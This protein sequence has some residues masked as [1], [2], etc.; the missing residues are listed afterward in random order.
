MSAKRDL[1]LAK[2]SN[3]YDLTVDDKARFADEAA[4][5]M[6]APQHPV[7]SK[8]A[9]AVPKEAIV[10]KEVQAVINRLLAVA[11]GQQLQTRPKPS[12]TKKRMLVGLA[13]PQI[14]ESVRIIVVDTSIGPDRKHAGKLE[15]FINPKI[16][17]RSRETAEGREGC[18]SAGPVWGLVRRPIALKL[19][20]FAPDGKQVERIFEDFTARIVQH[21]CDHL[22]GIRFP[23]RITNDKKRHWVHTEE[24]GDYPEYITRW[25]RLCSRERWETFICQL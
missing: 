9:Y 8:I 23:D 18:F 13:A 2:P 20:A 16:I 25:P 14:G 5:G 1:I 3:T 24:L 12:A 22:D 4:L 15:C 21:E 11:K 6:V 7:L 19:Q 10:G 17:W